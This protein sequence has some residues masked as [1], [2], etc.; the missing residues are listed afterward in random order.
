MKAIDNKDE[1][2]VGQALSKGANV[3]M[4]DTFGRTPLCR[5][6]VVG[7]EAVLRLLLKYDA[8]VDAKDA[9]G[10]P[11]LMCCKNEAVMSILLENGA[12][13]DARDRAGYTALHQAVLSGQETVVQLLLKY[14]ANIGKKDRDGYTTFHRAAILGHEAVVQLLLKYGADVNAKDWNGDT[15]LGLAIS[16]TK[17]K[18]A[19]I[20]RD[21]GGLVVGTPVGYQTYGTYPVT[22][23]SKDL[24]PPTNSLPQVKWI[25]RSDKD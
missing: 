17:P 22:Q 7:D 3:N 4:R 16:Y 9:D 14:G 24:T 12:S 2:R 11:A 10:S 1:T 13:I 21:A 8:D 15:P 6:V 23:H 25:W 20:L 5:A 19:K 18:V